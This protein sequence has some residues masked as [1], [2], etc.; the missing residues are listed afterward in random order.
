MAGSGEGVEG[1][2]GSTGTTDGGGGGSGFG[3]PGV[4]ACGG[5][6]LGWGGQFGRKQPSIY[7]CVVS[8]LCCASNNAI[9]RNQTNHKSAKS[10]LTPV[11]ALEK[12]I[13]VW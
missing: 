1:D 7:C 4:C 2:A 10:K 8:V 13:L 12:I 3:V 6:V 11:L 9:I 5:G